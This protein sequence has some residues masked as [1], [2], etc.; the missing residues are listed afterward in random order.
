MRLC[1]SKIAIPSKAPRAALNVDLAAF[2]NKK[3]CCIDLDCCI[4]ED[5]ERVE[6]QDYCFQ[7][8]NL[9]VND[10]PIT[11]YQHHE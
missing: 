7:G 4:H 5:G 10:K 9:I 8:G 6:I 2:V 3:P 11:E 1:N